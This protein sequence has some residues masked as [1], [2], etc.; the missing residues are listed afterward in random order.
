MKRWISIL[1][2]LALLVTLLAACGTDGP[3]LDDEDQPLRVSAMSAQTTADPAAAVNTGGD[4]LIYHL[5]E[6]LMKWVDDGTGAAQLTEGIAQNYTVEENT[7][8]SMVYTFTIRA[9]A[10]WSDGEP[11]T[12]ADFVYA[13]QRLFSLETAPADLSLLSLVEGYADAYQAKDGS[14]LTGVEAT[15]D[16]ILTVRLTTPCAY[17][18]SEV[19]GGAMTMP[20]R[21]DLVTAAGWEPGKVTNGA[22]TLASLTND[23][24]VLTRSETYY[25]AEAEGPAA[26][27]FT[28][29]TGQAAYEALT[30]GE[31]D[32]VSSLP[33]E[34]AEALAETEALQVSPLAS[35]TALLLN[36]QAAPFDNEFVREA[37]AAVVDQ[38][39]LT[40]AVCSVTDIAATGFVPH[41]IA[42]RNDQWTDPDAA[43]SDD[44][45]V[46]PDDLL[47]ASN[48]EADDTVWDFR[49][50]GDAEA[51]RE[52]LTMEERL[53]AAKNDMSQAGY[54]DGEDF[55]AVTFLYE[56]TAE[57]RAVAEYLR[58]LWQESLGV[59]IQLQACTLKE[60]KDAM[61]A[62]EYALGI[63]QFDAAYDDATAFLRRWK[64]T[65]AYWAGNL[66]GYA[67]QAYDLL[68]YAA[69]ITA[70]AAGREACLHDAEELLLSSCAVVPLYYG[71]TAAQ[72]ADGLTGVYGNAMGVWFFGS[73]TAS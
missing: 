25:D 56:D 64:S 52:E 35:T 62:G 43:S 34:A 65:T 41:G 3:A 40:E 48:Q 55:P 1:I 60:L 28:W 38:A 22:Y 69:D 36:T 31:L 12:A 58:D 67:N 53:S 45:A 21:E 5:Y 20:L 24:A 71:G 32:F 15:G 50:V 47:D 27:Q 18:L 59:T 51:P 6:N 37:F 33:E 42:N 9:D 63:F 17:F 61:L 73:V 49:A 14:L 66:V 57:S 23:G 46:T 10:V 54:P 39:A 68:L 16:Q 7:D 13:W 70:S 4:T 44:E 26:I 11:V 29:E 72:L 30:A 19:C 8:G 2:C